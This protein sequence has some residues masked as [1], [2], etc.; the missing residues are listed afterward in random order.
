[1]QFHNANVY[2]LALA[3]VAFVPADA[4]RFAPAEGSTLT[5]TI[6]AST[7]MVSDS[8]EIWVND[9]KQEAGEGSIIVDDST[10]IVIAD[11]YAKVGKGRPLELKRT[12]EKLEGESSQTFKAGEMEDE[13]KK[14]QK[15]ALEGLTILF[16]WNDKEEAYEPSFPEGKGDETLLER[17]K[18]DMDL[19]AFLP[20]S[21]VKEDAK[22]TV[23][24]GAAALFIFPN[25]Q[26]K[27]EDAEK[28][29]GEEDRSEID[30]ELTDNLE[31]KIEAHFKG[32]RE[33]DGQTVA[34]I[35]LKGELKSKADMDSA[36]QGKIEITISGDLTGEILWDTKAKHVRSATAAFEQKV[37]YTA[38][39]SYENGGESAKVKQMFGLSGTSKFEIK[40]GK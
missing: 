14:D 18:E 37:T 16:K 1:M 24:A 3:A 13:R 21:D 4:P 34:V 10:H 36:A 7:H 35:E 6:T 32:T 19:R 28:E 9:E 40:A 38:S 33:E 2:A 22:W 11:E 29:E 17:L 39:M 30:H 12:Y 31:G 8:M 25:G 26:V 23:K 5:K 15:S 27:L 20:D